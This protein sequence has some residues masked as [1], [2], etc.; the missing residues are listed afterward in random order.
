MFNIIIK[1]N[2]SILKE[3]EVK[4]QSELF[5]TDHYLFRLNRAKLIWSLEHV[6]ITKNKCSRFSSSIFSSTL[7]K[8]NK[9]GW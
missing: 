6:A 9:L 5:S 4:K 7:K 2:E 1:R 3:F 8:M